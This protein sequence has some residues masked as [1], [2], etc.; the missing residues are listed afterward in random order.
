MAILS[1]FTAMYD[2][3]SSTILDITV[4]YAAP[5][6]PSFGIPS[7]PNIKTALHIILTITAD[8]PIT[9]LTAARPVFLR[10]IRYTCDIAHNT[11]DNATARIYNVP[12]VISS[13]SFVNILISLSGI[14]NA[15]IVNILPD[16]RLANNATG[17]IFSIDFT[18]CFP[19]YWDT[20]IP[21]PAVI[22]AM[23]KLRINCICP[24]RETA[25]NDA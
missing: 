5:R 10:R 21:E 13:C 15:R 8:E 23:N 24:A 18:S 16:K 22:P 14:A 17:I 4:A 6:I 11:Y 9:E 1:L 7:N 19:Q 20:I 3:T 12:F 2:Q 25:D